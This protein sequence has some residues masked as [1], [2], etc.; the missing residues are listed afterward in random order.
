MLR[1]DALAAALAPYKD[2]RVLR[3]RHAMDLFAG[4][5]DEVLKKSFEGF[6]WNITAN[7]CCRDKPY[8]KK[9]LPGKVKMLI[10]W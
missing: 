9:G 3:L 4:W 6:A 10:K 2:A 1:Q 5:D 8:I 7:W